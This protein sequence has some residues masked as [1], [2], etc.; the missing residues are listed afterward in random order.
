MSEQGNSRYGKGG[1]SPRFT[2]TRTDGK[3]C[4][5]EARY[6]VMDG[7]GADPHAVKAIRAYAESVAAENGELARDLFAMLEPGKWPADMAQHKDAA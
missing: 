3:L 7:G 6:M 5:A 4:R 1:F 2:V